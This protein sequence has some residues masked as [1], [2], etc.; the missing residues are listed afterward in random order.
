M[1]HASR[2]VLPNRG[3]LKANKGCIEINIAIVNTQNGSK[4]LNVL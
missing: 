1:I 3:A 4:F 2:A